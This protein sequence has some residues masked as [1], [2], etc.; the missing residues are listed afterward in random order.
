M[1]VAEATFNN[2]CVYKFDDGGAASTFNVSIFAFSKTQWDL[3]VDG[4]TTWR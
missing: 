1:C 2:L 3:T 4:G